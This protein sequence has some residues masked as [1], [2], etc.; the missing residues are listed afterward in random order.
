MSN[1]TFFSA[2]S[3]SSVKKNN[4]SKNFH[5]FFG[6][7]SFYFSDCLLKPVR[8]AWKFLSRKSSENLQSKR[9]TKSSF[10]AD[11][12]SM[13]WKFT[14]E[15]QSASFCLEKLIRVVFSSSNS[16]CFGCTFSLSAILLQ[17]ILDEMFWFVLNSRWI[18][19]DKRKMFQKIY[20]RCGDT[21]VFSYFLTCNIRFLLLKQQQKKNSTQ[22]DFFCLFFVFVSPT[23]HFR[24]KVAKQRNLTWGYA[25][26]FISD[27]NIFRFFLSSHKNY[28]RVP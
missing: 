28:F 16:L 2:F 3:S 17:N 11:F 21:W 9:L 20:S 4:L 8:R 5:F 6:A 13:F 12:S 23:K 1:F 7:L 15:D 14:S 10:T 22:F 26:R 24:K 18:W 19:L 25:E 27:C